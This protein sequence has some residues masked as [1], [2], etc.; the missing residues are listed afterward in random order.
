MAKKPPLGSS[1]TSTVGFLQAG[2]GRTE[3]QQPSQEEL[4]RAETPFGRQSFTPSVDSAFG[5]RT[6]PKP[7]R[8]SGASGLPAEQ[9][10]LADGE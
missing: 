6:P 8:P 4:N 5:K 10:P 7:A 9:A 2:A 1:P 3:D